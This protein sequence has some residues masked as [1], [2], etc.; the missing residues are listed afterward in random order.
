MS[1]LIPCQRKKCLCRGTSLSLTRRYTHF[2]CLI[3]RE[4]EREANI[5]LFAFYERINDT[6]RTLCFFLGSSQLSSSSACKI[7]LIPRA[8]PLLARSTRHISITAHKWDFKTVDCH[9]KGADERVFLSER[10]CFD[11]IKEINS[12]E[13]MWF[14]GEQQSRLVFF[15][16]KHPFLW[17]LSNVLSSESWSVGQWQTSS[18]IQAL[19]AAL[20]FDYIQLQLQS[21]SLLVAHQTRLMSPSTL[22]CNNQI[23]ARLLTRTG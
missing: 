19:R 13:F 11:F 22:S 12:V 5:H 9:T 23:N 17:H 18:I 1:D 7:N 4:S 10:E 16:M 21:L 3:R 20:T 2:L 15:L 6:R 8:G 14:C